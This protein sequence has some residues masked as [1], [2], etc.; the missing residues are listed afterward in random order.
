M[1]D[2]L[3]NEIKTSLDWDFINTVQILLKLLFIYFIDLINI[4]INVNQSTERNMFHLCTMLI[5]YYCYAPLAIKTNRLNDKLINKR[6]P[7]KKL[8]IFSMEFND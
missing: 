7:N 3:A 5:F 1:F 8:T 2:I 6:A 4:L